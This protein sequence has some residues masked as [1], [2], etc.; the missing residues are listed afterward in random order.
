MNTL[1]LLCCSTAFLPAESHGGLPYSTFNLCKAL[2][3]A[4][5]DVAVITTDRNGD[6]RLDVSTDCWT[7]YEEVAVREDDRRA[8][9]LRTVNGGC[10]RV[11]TARRLCTQFRHALGALGLACVAL[12]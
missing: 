12:G 4:G 9:S 1:R 5:A 6:R 10:F 3:R 11:P 7:T 2:K 8:L